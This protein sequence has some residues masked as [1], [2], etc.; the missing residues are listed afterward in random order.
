MSC[1]SNSVMFLVLWLGF[2]PVDLLWNLLKTGYSV[3]LEALSATSRT[4]LLLHDSHICSSIHSYMIFASQQ[5]IFQFLKLAL[6]S[7]F[8]QAGSFKLAASLNLM[9]LIFFFV[10]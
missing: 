7:V 9:C 1:F 10:I 6:N 2:F 5:R 3:V 4:E 8:Q